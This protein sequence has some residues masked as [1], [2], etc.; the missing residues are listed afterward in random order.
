[1][2]HS[3]DDE[4]N[5]NS[6]EPASDSKEL[7]EGGLELDRQE[8]TQ[9]YHKCSSYVSDLCLPWLWRGARLEF[10][11]KRFEDAVRGVDGQGVGEHEVDTEK[12]LGN[13]KDQVL[14]E[15]VNYE[16]LS[17]FSE[18][19]VVHESESDEQNSQSDNGSC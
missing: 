2:A 1:M 11:N 16:F 4:N 6:Q 3:R 10:E 9:E 17:Q 8:A 13:F 19:V 15:A 5:C 7:V 12:Q 18:V 14:V